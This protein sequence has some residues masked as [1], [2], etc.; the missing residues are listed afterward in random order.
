MPHEQGIAKVISYSEYQSNKTDEALKTITEVAKDLGVPTYVIRFWET[1]FPEIA[2]LL[3]S[4]GRRYYAKETVSKIREIKHFL[5][6]E[7]YTIRGV[8]QLLKSQ[9]KVKRTHRIEEAML[10]PKT[11]KEIFKS[12]LVALRDSLK[13]ALEK[14]KRKNEEG[15][16]DYL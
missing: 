8:Q 10:K 6:E 9:Q 5:Y 12:E 14:G 7:G 11:E 15:D 16:G 2:P 4:G 1:K 13:S 3:R